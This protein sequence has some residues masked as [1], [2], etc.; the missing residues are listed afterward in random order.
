MK[1]NS[2][3]VKSSVGISENGERG[4]E[5]RNR[6][7]VGELVNFKGIDFLSRLHGHIDIAPFTPKPGTNAFYTDEDEKLTVLIEPS[8]LMKRAFV[9]RS[10]LELHLDNIFSHGSPRQVRIDRKIVNALLATKVFY[11]GSRS[12]EAII[13]MSFLE[14]GNRFEISHLPPN[15]QLKMHVD[16]DNFSDCL[17]CDIDAIWRR[18]AERR[19]RSV[20]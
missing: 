9:L 16:I 10:L 20:G 5:I 19:P 13:R 8:Y 15:N 12:M 4:N 18:A 14:G 17:E 11:H 1:D 3:L 2:D 7:K 6:G